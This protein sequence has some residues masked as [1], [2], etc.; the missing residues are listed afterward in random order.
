MPPAEIDIP[1]FRPSLEEFSD[2]FSFVS[3]IDVECASIGLAKIIPPAGWWDP[4]DRYEDIADLQIPAPISQ[5]ISGKPGIFN[6]DLVEKKPMTLAA[7]REYAE[8]Y[9]ERNGKQLQRVL[10][11]CSGGRG[12]GGSIS[13]EDMD[14]IERC[15]WRGL[16]TTMDAPMYGADISVCVCA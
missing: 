9:D 3:K 14:A 8:K 4:G 13:R 6:V 10:D 15:F 5:C 11:G 16:N 7:F 2:F 12:G 1:T